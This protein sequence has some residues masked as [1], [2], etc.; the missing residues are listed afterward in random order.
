MLN[1]SEEKYEAGAIS[2]EMHASNLKTVH[3]GLLKNLSTLEEL[4]STMVS[5]YGETLAA[6]GEELVLYTERM[7]H[8]NS[9]LDHYKNLLTIVGE[10]TNYKA[11][12]TILRGQ[13]K[14]LQNTAE[15]SK[16]TYEMYAKEAEEW[17]L[18]MDAATPGTAEFELY[19]QAW[20]DAEA[21]S[22]EA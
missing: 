8:H 3:S 20:Q 11:M 16:S 14:V 1:D 7:E 9:V 2:D 22:R 19:E 13:A 5:Y 4:D 6:A 15:V 21:A 18:K 10:E 12:D 17:K